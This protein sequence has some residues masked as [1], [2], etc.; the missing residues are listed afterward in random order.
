MIKKII[1][2]L[3]II[4]LLYSNGFATGIKATE[5]TNETIKD[6]LKSGNPSDLPFIDYMDSFQYD[7]TQPLKKFNLSSFPNKK[8]FVGYGIYDAEQNFCKYIDNGVSIKIKEDYENIRKYNYHSYAISKTPHTLQGCINDAIKFGGQLVS[9]DSEAENQYITTT[10]RKP[11]T[12]AQG[13]IISSTVTAD[14]WVGLSR[15]SCMLPYIN[16]LGKEQKYFNWTSLK[17]NSSDCNSSKLGTIFTD[18]GTW[19]KVSTS[20]KHKCI[21]ETDSEDITKPIK[22]CAPWWRIEREFKT[23]PKSI[24]NGVDIYSL[25]QAD[26]PENMRVCIKYKKT[27]IEEAKKLPRREYTCTSYYKANLNSSCIKDPYQSMCFVDECDGYPK[28]ACKEKEGSPF[29]GYKEYTKG[30]VLV[31]GNFTEIKEKVGIKTHIWDCPGIAMTEDDCEEFANVVVFPKECDGAYGSDCQ[32]YSNCL[33]E[34]KAEF[35]KIN[36]RDLNTTENK[37][38]INKCK[39]DFSCLKLYPDK[40]IDPTDSNQV[41]NGELKYLTATCP[42]KNYLDKNIDEQILKFIPQIQSRTKKTCEEYSKYIIDE[43]VLQICKL[44]REFEEFEVESSITAEDIYRVNPDCI[45]VNKI[46]EAR[47]PTSVKFDYT[48]NGYAKTIIKKTYL[49]GQEEIEENGT[50]LGLEDSMNITNFF[51]NVDLSG[52]NLKSPT[53]AEQEEAIRNSPFSQN[54]IID[55][56]ALLTKENFNGKK[57]SGKFTDNDGANFYILYNNVKDEVTC[58]SY[59]DFSNNY[60]EVENYPNQIIGTKTIYNTENKTCKV[61]IPK[62]DIEGDK[63]DIFKSSIADSYNNIVLKTLNQ[64]DYKKCQEY[65]LGLDGI[66][67]TKKSEWG[68]NAT[69]TCTIIIGENIEAEDTSTPVLADA[70]ISIPDN[71]DQQTCELNPSSGFYEGEFNGVRDIYSIQ[72]VTSNGKS[73]FELFTNYKSLPFK[74]NVVIMNDQELFPINRI[75]LIQDK[76]KY[77]A[78][79][80]QWSMSS[81]KPKYEWAMK[82]SNGVSGTLLTASGLGVVI[83]ALSFFGSKKKLNKMN[84]YWSI[85]K[86]NPNYIDNYST[87]N[88]RNFKSNNIIYEETN[89]SNGTILKKDFEILIRNQYKLKEKD[90]LCKGYSKETINRIKMEVENKIIEGYPG[91]KWYHRTSTKENKTNKTKNEIIS[92]AVNSVYL[93]AVTGVSIIVPYKGSYQVSVYDKNNELLG[94][95]IIRED[96]FQQKGDG[97][98]TN[99]AFFAKIMLGLSMQLAPN[100]K[101]LSNNKTENACRYST[102]VEWGGGLSGVYL[103]NNTDGLYH[104]CIKS[105]NAWVASKAA[106]TIKIKPINSDIEHVIKLEKPMP[107]ANRITL[108]TLNKEEN[109]KY[110]CY[111][112][113]KE[114]TDFKL[115]EK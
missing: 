38:I 62:H 63:G 50:I 29:T 55:L 58:S 103:E 48:N 17:Y 37:N 44:S 73:R 88:K 60:S 82:A 6:F 61:Y 107:Y 102:M 32:G 31:N 5:R 28:R 113:F 14:A 85:Q 105:N 108:V 19:E 84:T 20:E 94:S 59:T 92:K 24:F 56:Y 110:R 52:T 34:K 35:R 30:E 89:I 12:N 115:E 75:P 23:K 51:K 78:N 45:R 90:L 16:T 11:V 79:I 26:I 99:T 93:N 42:N 41:I 33:S 25:H 95:A 68:V 114:C 86:L 80:T 27:S 15:T 104:N 18:Y 13:Q 97:A 74:S 2:N 77:D 1:N 54:F 10:F 66:V 65:A 21:I 111:K 112:P 39:K 40:K 72:E 3:L 83:Y 46:M 22:I 91:L 53:A 7:R 69:K 9:I 67:A 71:R 47:P 4:A 101:N 64:M 98:A 8:V 106:T 76:L 109:R 96:E 36:K 70:D 81:R 49:N 100:F 43:D 87:Y 57:S